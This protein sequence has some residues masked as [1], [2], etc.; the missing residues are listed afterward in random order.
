MKKVYV[1][2]QETTWDP[3]FIA[4]YSSIEKLV[5]GLCEIFKEEDIFLDE[6]KVRNQ[7]EAREELGALYLFFPDMYCE[8]IE[9]S[10]R[11]LYLVQAVY[12]DV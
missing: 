5:Q 10:P 4:V 6:T 12:M 2:R 9:D 1:V 11:Y 7:I 3:D 8:N